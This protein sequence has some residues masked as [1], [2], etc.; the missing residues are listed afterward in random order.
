LGPDAKI[1]SKPRVDPAPVMDE[2]SR[3]ADHDEMLDIVA[4]HEHKPA[5]GVHHRALDNLQ[6]SA[7]GTQGLLAEAEPDRWDQA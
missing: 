2:V 6:A 7:A 3:T 5:A 1:I 4:A